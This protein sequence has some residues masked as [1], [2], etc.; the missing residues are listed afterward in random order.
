L[1]IYLNAGTPTAC[2]AASLFS[3]LSM[4]GDNLSITVGGQNR[5]YTISY[6]AEALRLR[7][8]NSASVVDTPGT[9]QFRYYYNVSSST[10][11]IFAVANNAN[12]LLTLN[13]HSGNYYHQL[14]FS[15]NGCLYHR[16]FSNTALNT[17]RSQVQQ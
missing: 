9:G 6:A 3:N 14:G 5:V 10:S 11:G 1:P 2:T 17:T 12:G 16:A 7:G 8:T 4:S 15:S 13:T